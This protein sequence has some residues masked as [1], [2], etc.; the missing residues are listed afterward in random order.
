MMNIFPHSLILNASSRCTCEQAHFVNTTGEDGC[1]LDIT[2][3]RY[4]LTG[5]TDNHLRDKQ[6]YDHVWNSA[7]LLLNNGQTAVVKG[8]FRLAEVINYADLAYRHGV[9]LYY[10]NTCDSNCPQFHVQNQIKSQLSKL[11]HCV[12]VPGKEV[13]QLFSKP[14][15]PYK[16][17]AV[18]DV[19]G[20]YAA[21][22]QA[23]SHAKQNQQFVVWLGDIVDYGAQNLKCVKLAYQSV[24]QG[25]AH[26]IW[27]NH[28]RKISKWIQRDWGKNYKGTLSEANLCTIREIQALNCSSKS[29]FHSA[30]QTL[31][32]S[33]TQHWVINNWMFVHGAAN[34]DMWHKHCHR[35]PGVMGEL[36]Y[37]GEV[38]NNQTNSSGYP[39]RT[40][41]WV[42][43]VPHGHNVV[44]GHDWLDHDKCQ[45]VFKH[46][47]QG[48]RVI[49][50]DTGSS[51]GGCLS[52]VEIDI[53]QNYAQPIQFVTN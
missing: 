41:K 52:A 17:L 21:M 10:V 34:P 32:N 11:D 43:L 51:K 33:S 19:H 29:R 50:T 16:I 22:Q 26:M 25:Q 30:W 46:G 23:L 1:L 38:V 20:N 8:I 35:L 3:Q 24:Q 27:G 48:G 40:W 49:C 2:Q 13:L 15:P 37:F 39:L 36:A 18:G 31:E 53:L 28:E 45:V 5:R 7:Q 47:S 12:V 14:N 6:I 44:V 4:L 42:D 9:C